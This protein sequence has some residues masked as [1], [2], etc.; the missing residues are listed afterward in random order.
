MGANLESEDTDRRRLAKRFNEQVKLAANLLNNLAVGTT[1]GAILVPIASDRPLSAH[2]YEI[3]IPA[4][5]ALH[6]SAQVAIRLLLKS[7]D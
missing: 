2:V 3:W 4:A 7:E 5:V 1:V 6:L